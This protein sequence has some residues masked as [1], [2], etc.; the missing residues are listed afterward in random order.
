MGLGGA[1]GVVIVVG[2]K[3]FVYCTYHAFSGYI[4]Y[5]I[6]IMNLLI[7][8][9]TQSKSLEFLLYLYLS[10]RRKQEIRALP[11]PGA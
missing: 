9:Q 1:R 11:G 6:L 10:P 2:D 7:S 4:V 5:S 3:L 8:T